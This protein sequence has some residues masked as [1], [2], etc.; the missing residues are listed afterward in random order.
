M[1][2]LTVPQYD[3]GYNLTFT[4]K[5]NAGVVYNLTD[6]VARL[7]IWIGGNR[8]GTIVNG[9]CVLTAPTF[10][11]ATYTVGSADFRNTGN[12]MGKIELTKLGI[13]ESTKP[14]TIQITENA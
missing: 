4:V 1:S 12:Y 7:R 5:D 11:T 6:Y 10:G 9:T 13:V 14:F 3:Y 8:A 2:D